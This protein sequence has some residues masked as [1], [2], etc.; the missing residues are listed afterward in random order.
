MEK[1]GVKYTVHSVSE[2][3]KN[4]LDQIDSDNSIWQ[5]KN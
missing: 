5:E 2:I 3:S 4:Y 1:T